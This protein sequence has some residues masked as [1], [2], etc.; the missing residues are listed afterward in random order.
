MSSLA[1]LLVGATRGYRLQTRRLATSVP[2]AATSGMEARVNFSPA[3]RSLFDEPLA[4]TVEGL[5]PEQQVTLRASL[6]DE[7]GILFES[8][9]LYQAD[10]H[11]Q[12][13]LSRSPALEGGSFS[14]LEPMGLL[15]SLKPTE[16]LRRLVK[17]DVQ[18]PFR[19]EVEVLGSHNESLA[20]GTHER[21]FLRDGVRRIP[22]RE[23]RI[24]AM[25]FLPP[26]ESG[27]SG[28]LSAVWAFCSSDKNAHAQC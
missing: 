15:W 6:R 17:R 13:E 26:G 9:A 24:R 16:P 8:R 2:V 1:R 4:I 19:L 28:P 3:G 23:G 21:A 18:T 7:S 20:R 25:L 11:G 12:V 14:G 10:S 5:P 22:V 27:S